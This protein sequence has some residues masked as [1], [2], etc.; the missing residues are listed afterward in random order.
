MQQ[1]KSEI[2]AVNTPLG[3]LYGRDAIYVDKLDYELNHRQVTLTGEFNGGLAS[4]SE[5]DDF[6]KYTL[7][8]EGV[9]Y[10]KATELDLHGDH[11]PTGKTDIKSDWLEY[12]QSP[13]LERAKQK[14]KRELKELRHFILFTYDD[15]FEIACQSYQLEL[16]PNEHHAE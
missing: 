10:F 8:F 2:E 9:Y 11:L 3:H 13:L 4:E 7:C 12:R 15:V 5:S 1:Q 14:G 6:V 16:H